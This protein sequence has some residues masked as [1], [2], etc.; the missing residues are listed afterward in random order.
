MYFFRSIVVPLLFTL[1]S[2]AAAVSADT[3]YDLLYSLYTMRQ[4]QGPDVK[5][6]WPSDAANANAQALAAIINV[7]RVEQSTLPIVIDAG[8][9]KAL[10][11]FGGNI[12]SA[13][14]LWSSDSSSTKAIVQSQF[15]TTG[16]GNSGQYWV[17]VMSKM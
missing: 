16:L 9:R 13:F 8:S 1:Q 11:S 5:A 15:T 4:M 17:L 12:S 7:V 14:Q 3:Q 2:D 10:V 6:L